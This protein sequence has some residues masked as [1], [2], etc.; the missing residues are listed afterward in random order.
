VASLLATP[1]PPGCPLGYGLTMARTVRAGKRWD[2]WQ[3]G[4]VYITARGVKSYIIREKRSGRLYQRTTGCHTEHAAI[5]EYERFDKDPDNYKPRG[6]FP[7]S[8]L[9]LDADLGRAYVAHCAAPEA[10]GGKG[11]GKKWLLDKARCMDWWTSKL[12]GRDLRQLEL[13][14]LRARLEPNAR[15][16]PGYQHKVEVLKDFYGWLREKRDFPH[17]KDPTI[18]LLVPQARPGSRRKKRKAFTREQ[19]E[20]LVARVGEP[21]RWVLLV[22]AGTGW[23]VSE[24]GRFARA[25][26]IESMPGH[27]NDEHAIAVLV[28]PMHKSGEEHR[29]AVTAETLSGAEAL[30]KHGGFSESRLYK[31]VRAACKAVTPPIDPIIDPGQYRHAVATWAIEAGADP[32]AVAAFLGHRSPATTKRFYALHAVPPR[33]PTLSS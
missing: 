31:A 22:L 11:N 18:G 27:V 12:A 4:R 3:Y 7:E 1:L 25:G 5:Q 26:S 30:L 13:R 19:H 10:E 32:A 16:V 28:C 21:Y 20:A 17:S 24:V 15:R 6:G 14:D 33:V 29:T 23:H 2:T 8:P 9:T